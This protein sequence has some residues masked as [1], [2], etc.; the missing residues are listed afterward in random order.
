MREEVFGLLFA[1]DLQF[2]LLSCECEKL[3]NL[4]GFDAG[5][6]TLGNCEI[7]SKKS[8]L[9]EVLV[10]LREF[11]LLILIYFFVMLQIKPDFI[12]CSIT[13]GRD[14]TDKFKTIFG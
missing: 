6:P 11:V 7:G 5:T 4:V 8:G 13:F 9:V 3:S 1:K 2:S 10:L 14:I 12:L